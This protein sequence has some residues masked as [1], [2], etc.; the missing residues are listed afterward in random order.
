MTFITTHSATRAALSI[1]LMAASFAAF[2]ASG[3]TMM[4]SQEPQITVGMTRADVDA[5]L[6]RPAHN[7]KYVNEPGRSWT[8]G[9]TGNGVAANTV[10][11]VDFTAD[12]KV[13][14]A[15]E[16]VEVMSNSK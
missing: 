3:F 12:G 10:F 5:L 8:Y 14:H 6:G 13:L 15:N 9:V 16:R 11:D 1:G 2:S 4:R 7:L